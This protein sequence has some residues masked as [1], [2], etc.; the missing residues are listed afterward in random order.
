MPSPPKE[1]HSPVYNDEIKR[2]T[3][4][5]LKELKKP[6]HLDTFAEPQSL[7]PEIKRLK[8]EREKLDEER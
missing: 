4:E 1:Q 5:K 7:S 6:I 3:K 2:S 8:E